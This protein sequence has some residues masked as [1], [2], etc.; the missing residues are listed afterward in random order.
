M[1]IIPWHDEYWRVEYALGAALRS[2]LRAAPAGKQHDATR[3]PDRTCVLRD[4]S[5]NLPPMSGV[6]PD[7][8]GETSERLRD[9]VPMPSRQLLP[10]N[11]ARIAHTAVAAANAESEAFTAGGAPIIC[12]AVAGIAQ[13]GIGRRRGDRRNWGY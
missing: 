6:C 1:S 9:R 13:R 4:T 11:L 7:H 5:G 8:R 12:H 10:L 3:P 2:P